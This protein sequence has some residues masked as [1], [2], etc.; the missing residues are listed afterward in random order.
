MMESPETAYY[1]SVVDDL[2]ISNERIHE[3]LDAIRREVA[4]LRR[5]IATATLYIS[6]LNDENT[7]D[8]GALLVDM[9]R[10]IQQYQAYRKDHK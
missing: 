10:Q 6:S 1:Q 4:I 5:I 2:R 7:L 9:N 8:E 3:E